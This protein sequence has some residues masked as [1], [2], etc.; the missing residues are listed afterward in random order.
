MIMLSRIR[1]LLAAPVFEDEDKTRVASLLNVILLALV[2][3]AMMYGIASSFMFLDPVPV[4]GFVS[5]ATLLG[6]G[7]RSLMRR[8]RVKLASVL[9]SSVLWVII[10]LGVFVSDGVRS[11]VFS[12][13]F[14]VILINGLLSDGHGGIG[15]AGLSILAGL[16]ILRAETS[17][18]LPPALLPFTPTSTW[19]LLTAIL[20]LVAVLLSLATHSIREALE[21]AR[22]NA[23]ALT[24]SNRELRDSRAALEEHARNLRRRSVQLQ[25]SAEVSRAATTILETDQLMRQVVELIRERFGLD[26]VGLFLVEE[27]G[28]WAVLQAATGEAGRRKCAQGHRRKVGETSIVGYVISRGQPCIALDVGTDAAVPGNSDLPLVRSQMALPLRARG[29]IIGA[30]DVQSTEPETFSDEEM[31]VFQMMADQVVVA[32]ENARLYEAVQQELVERTRAEEALRDSEERFRNIFENSPIG[33]YRTTSDGQI[34]L[35]NPALVRMLGYSS[36]EELAQ[37]DLESRG[38]EPEYPRSDFKRR[39]KSEGKIT[40]L[41]SAWTRKDGATLF[42]R[43]HTKVIRDAGNKVYYEGTVEDIT[44]RKRAE[45]QLQRYAAGLEQANEELERFTYVASHNLRGPLVNLKGFAAELR[46]AL[47]AVGSV[48]IASLPHLDEKQ[49]QTVTTAIEEDIPEALGF[50][51]SSVSDMDRLVN[52]I[53]KLSSLGRRELD[54]K[55]I[56]MNGLVQATLESLAHQLEEHQVQVSVGPLPEVIA[57]QTSMEQVLS[58]LLTNAVIYLDPDRA[59]EIEITAERNRHETTF[60]VRDNGRG[61]AEDDLDKAYAPFRRAGRQDVPGE[62]MGL[63]TVQTLLRRHG[64]R[65]WCESKPGVGTTFTFTIPHHLDEGSNYV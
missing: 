58:N 38:F 4:L 44:E 39:I 60:H 19:A 16:A 64:G 20:A 54:L 13:Y 9:L 51:D 43:E 18:A 53:Q 5:V 50:I 42:V 27:P 34:M 22:R 7:V 61:I 41:E 33:I 49:R 6:L 1:H 40:G 35:A 24:E 8:G 46:A 29:E 14:V 59:G 63:P 28:E 30:L 52:A 37:R 55:P 3:L 21:R 15:F 25:A 31:T 47:A 62:G 57:D 48:V 12:A 10:T 32:I 56:D 65:I 36:F 26:Y 23:Q 2:P 17:A 45:E 11:P